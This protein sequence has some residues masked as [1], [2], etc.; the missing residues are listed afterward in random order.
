MQMQIVTMTTNQITTLGVT[1]SLRGILTFMT[2][3]VMVTM[4]LTQ[5]V[6]TQELRS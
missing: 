3:V 4:I 5:Y 2:L 1:R 6:M